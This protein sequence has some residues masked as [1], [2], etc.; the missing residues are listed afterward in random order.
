MDTHMVLFFTPTERQKIIDF[1]KA[2][3]YDV[4]AWAKTTL[5][6]AAKERNDDESFQYLVN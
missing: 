2:L 1:C 5:L 4:I 6:N 3:D